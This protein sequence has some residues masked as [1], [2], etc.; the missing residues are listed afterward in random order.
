VPELLEPVIGKP[1][2]DACTV[3]TG[4]LGAVDAAG[5]DAWLKREVLDP[6]AGRFARQGYT[7]TFDP[8]FVA[9]LSK[10]A[11]QGAALADFVDRTVA[12]ALATSLPSERG[13]LTA[14]IVDGKPVLVTAARQ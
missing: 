11:P 5:Q 1:L 2:L 3:V 9:W 8:P 12:P 4:T 13:A 10:S 14:T 6:L 7:V